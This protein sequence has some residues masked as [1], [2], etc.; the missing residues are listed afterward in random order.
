MSA[1]VLINREGQPVVNSRHQTAQAAARAA[2]KL[3][4][5]SM[6]LYLGPGKSW[7]GIQIGDVLRW[8]WDSPPEHLVKNLS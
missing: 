2:A 4:C 8:S 7:F 1:V 5:P 6:V 3:A